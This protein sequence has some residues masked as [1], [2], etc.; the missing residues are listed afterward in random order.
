MATNAAALVSVAVSSSDRT[1]RIS[2]SATNA[3]SDA[4]DCF[5]VADAGTLARRRYPVGTS[6]P[7]T[8]TAADS[9]IGFA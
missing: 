1:T 3:A 9:E 4:A 2:G 5:A 8:C 6:D 7:C